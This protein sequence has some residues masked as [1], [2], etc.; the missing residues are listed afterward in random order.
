MNRFPDLQHAA[1]ACGAHI[2]ARLEEAIGRSGRAMLAISGGSSPKPMFAFFGHSKFPWENVQLFWVDERAVLPTDAQSNF[3]LAA[4]A[5][6]E[7]GN[8]PKANVHRIQAELDPQQAAQIYA[9]ELQAAFG[10]GPGEIPEFDVIHQGMGPEGH[11][12]SLFPGE[13]LIDDRRG[14]VG[15]VWVEKVKM[16]RITMLP[17]VLIAARHTAIIVSG[18]EKAPTLDAVL[19]GSY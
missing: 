18:A 10:V 17:A 4:D 11:T 16:W 1:E 9:D 15:A 2:L 7:P 3:K 5:W 6:L 13:P 12:A 14:L 8:F 19:N